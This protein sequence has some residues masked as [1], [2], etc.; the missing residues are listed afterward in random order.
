MAF[1][2]PEFAIL[3]ARDDADDDD[4]RD[5][6][7]GG[8]RRQPLGRGRRPPARELRP[9]RRRHPSRPPLARARLHRG[10]RGR[11]AL[12]RAERPA[13]RQ[14]HP[15]AHSRHPRL[16]ARVHRSRR[17]VDRRERGD[18]LPRRHRLARQRTPR[19]HPGAADRV[20]PPRDRAARRADPHEL[21]V[22]GDDVR[23]QPPR[24]ALRGD[25]HGAAPAPGLPRLRHVRRR[26]GAS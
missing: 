7:V 1:Q 24:R 22:E 10:A 11:C 21:R 18:G 3:G 4:R 25:R 14:S 19:R 6:P 20:R 15:A 17:R 2:F 23:G 8:R 5:R 26:G 16:G 13:R 12:R 9:G